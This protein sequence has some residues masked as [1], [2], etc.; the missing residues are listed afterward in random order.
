M[1]IFSLWFT[2]QNP[3]KNLARLLISSFWNKLILEFLPL[4]SSYWFGALDSWESTFK[5]LALLGI[6]F[7]I[8]SIVGDHLSSWYHFW[9]SIFKLIALLRINFQADSIVAEWTHLNFL[10]C[11]DFVF[12][13]KITSTSSKDMNVK[14]PEVSL[15]SN[16]LWIWQVQNSVAL[17]L[18]LVTE[19]NDDSFSVWL[20]NVMSLCCGFTISHV[21]SLATPRFVRKK[22]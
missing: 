13:F 18:V 5:L 22:K 19:T 6:N 3:T 10:D 2:E 1:F 12:R 11:F 7:R 16:C 14:S 4:G 8:D 15:N 20:E 17:R 21:R 9:E